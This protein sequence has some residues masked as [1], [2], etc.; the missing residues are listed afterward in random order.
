MRPLRPT[1]SQGPET[2]LWVQAI[3]GHQ[4]GDGA[5]SNNE[6]ISSHRPCTA[7][8]PSSL[9]VVGLVHS[10]RTNVSLIYPGFLWDHPLAP[11]LDEAPSLCSLKTLESLNHGAY[12]TC[13]GPPPRG[14]ASRG[15]GV[16]IPHHSPRVQ[17]LT[18]SK[19]FKGVYCKNEWP[20]WMKSIFSFYLSQNCF[21]PVA[22]KANL[23]K[24]YICIHCKIIT[25]I[26]LINIHHYA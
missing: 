3:D 1:T 22:P 21:N 6:P 12:D 24:F 23:L 2:P 4:R 5:L 25:R 13:L 14:R 8:R 19:C 26:S 7:R 16:L 17:C 10:S 18:H 11:W 20:E 9:Q 15:R